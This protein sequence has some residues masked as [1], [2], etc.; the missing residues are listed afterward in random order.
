MTDRAFLSFGT[1]VAPRDLPFLLADCLAL[2]LA[3]SSVEDEDEEERGFL[4]GPS[5]GLGSSEIS[6]GI[7]VC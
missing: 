1:L 2:S 7:V 6:I 4:R 3:D 5:G